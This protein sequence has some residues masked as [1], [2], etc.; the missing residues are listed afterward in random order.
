MKRKRY[1]IKTASIGF[2]LKGIVKSFFKPEYQLKIYFGVPGSGKTTLAAKLAYKAI[3]KGI[4]VYSNV[5]IEGCYEIDAHNDLG[6]YK[7]E[8]ALIIIDEG[9]IEF[10]N[11]EYKSFPKKLIKFFKLHRHY[12]C[13]ICVFSQ[14]AV[15][16]DITLRRLAQVMYVCKRTFLPFVYKYYKIGIK[17]G[18]NELTKELCDEYYKIP[19]S[20]SRTL[21]PRYWKLFNSFDAPKLEDKDFKLW[22]FDKN[23]L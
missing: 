6:T 8:N 17:V 13:R 22:N 3:K 7:I 11:R 10:N 4:P 15:D 5:P 16:V 1:K 21:A 2:V 18:I 23:K 12:K 14:S 9:S 19:F 20:T